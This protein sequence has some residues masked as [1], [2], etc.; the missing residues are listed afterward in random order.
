MKIRKNGK[1]VRLT[2]SD[3]QRIVKRTLNEEQGTPLPQKCGGEI[4]TIMGLMSE[5]RDY[6]IKIQTGS[7]FG[8]DKNNGRDDLLIIT[9]PVNTICYC[10]KEEFFAEGI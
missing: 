8:L 3:L 1:V 7:D 9:N 10:T 6:K 4:K 5:N 2:E